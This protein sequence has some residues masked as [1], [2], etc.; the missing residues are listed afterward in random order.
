MD[1]V[2]IGISSFVAGL[3]SVFGVNKVRNGRNGGGTVRLHHKDIEA[4]VT[5][6]VTAVG[7]VKGV[8]DEVRTQQ[9]GQEKWREGYEAAKREG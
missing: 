3:A 8:V 9:I 2:I 1:E 5:P 4:I 6:I 7:E